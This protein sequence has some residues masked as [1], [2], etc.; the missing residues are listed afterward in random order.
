M[1]SLQSA[2]YICSIIGLGFAKQPEPMGYAAVLV[3]KL[4]A[5]FVALVNKG[6]QKKKTFSLW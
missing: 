4:I 3:E 2:R 6:G 5:F 1:F